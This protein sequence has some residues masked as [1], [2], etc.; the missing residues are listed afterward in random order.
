MYLSSD[1]V[2]VTAILQISILLNLLRI[3]IPIYGF[4]YWREIQHIQYCS[5]IASRNYT[6]I[7]TQFNILTS[8]LKIL[9]SNYEMA[10]FADATHISTSNENPSQILKNVCQRMFDRLLRYRCSYLFSTRDFSTISARWWSLF[11]LLNIQ[12]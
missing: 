6:Y 4:Y 12:Y 10:M 2:L 8:D 1:L 7:P 11:E 5:W 9:T 3:L